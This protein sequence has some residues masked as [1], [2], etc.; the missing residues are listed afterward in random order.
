MPFL[1]P[2]AAVAFSAISIGA[3]IAAAAGVTAFLGLSIATWSTIAMVGMAAT[4][5]ASVLTM[6]KAPK[7]ESQMDPGQQLGTKVIGSLG[8]LPVVYGRT[9]VG[10][11]LVY[12]STHG[13]NNKFWTKAHVLS[14]AGPIQE[15]EKYYASEWE[16]QLTGNPL[17]SL[18]T[19]SGLVGTEAGSKLYK[20]KVKVAYSLG[21][22]PEASTINAR[23]GGSLPLAPGA[24]SGVAYAL[25]QYDYDQEAFSGGD[26]QN[27][28]VIKG[29]KAYDP[30]LDST[31]TGGAGPQRLDDQ[32]T[33]VFT[34]NPYIA[35]LH[36][37]LG[38]YVGEVRTAGL[39]V[40]PDEIDWHAFITG[41]NVCDANDWK[42][43]GEVL[44]NDEPF[45]VLAA[46]LQAGCGVPISRGAQISCYVCAPQVSVR[47]ITA[48]DVVGSYENTNSTPWRGRK[49]RVVP[50]YRS[51]AKFWKAVQGD[52]IELAGAVEQDG[53]TKTYELNFGMVQDATQAHQLAA[54][55]LCNNREFLTFEVTCKPQLLGVRVGETIV[56]DLPDV[57]ANEIKCLVMGREF[58]PSSCTVRLSL[59]SETDTKH[60]FALGLTN[61]EPIPPTL[62]RFD[63][64]LV[65][66]PLSS[67][68]KAEG[69]VVIDP[70]GGETP[71]I[72]VTGACGNP[73]IHTIVIEH[74]LAGS[75]EWTHAAEGGRESTRF[76]LQSGIQGATAYDVA[77]SYR[78]VRGALSGRLILNDITT[79]S[80]VFPDQP[81]GPVDY[82]DLTGLPDALTIV[83]GYLLAE[84]LWEGNRTVQDALEAIDL[85]QATFDLTLQGVADDLQTARDDIGT[86][87]QNLI[88]AEGD[89]DVRM[90]G[91]DAAIRLVDPTAGSIGSWF[92]LAETNITGAVTRISGMESNSLVSLNDNAAFANFPTPSGM[93]A[94]WQNW[95]SSA[96]LSRVAGQVSP[97]GV[98]VIGP[99]NDNGGI[100]SILNP[101]LQN[102]RQNQWLVLEADVTLNSGS[103][104]SAALY[105]NIIT[106]G[107]VFLESHQI[108]FTI[109]PDN[110]GAVV[111]AGVVG[112]TYRYSKLIRVQHASA[113]WAEV[114]CMAHY[115]A[116]G[117][118]A[119]ANSITFHKAVLRQATNMEIEVG[120]ASVGSSLSAK[121]INADTVLTNGSL[122]SA[123]SVSNLS[124]ELSN[125]REG[126]PTLL[127]NIGTVRQASVDG[128]AGKASASEFSII[129]SEVEGARGGAASLGAKIG[130]FS[131]TVADALTGKASAT[132]VTTLEARGR[133][134]PNLIP[135]GFEN[136]LTGWVSA[137]NKTWVAVDSSWGRSVRMTNVP[138]SGI[139]VLHTLPFPV[140]PGTYYSITGDS[141][142]IGGTAI[143]YFDFIFFADDGSAVDGPQNIKS[144]AHDFSE[145]DVNRN[146]Y[147]VEAQ[148]PA[149]ATSAIA[150][151]IIDGASGVNYVGVRMV[152]AQ[153]GRLPMTPFSSEASQLQNGA[154][155]TTLKQVTVDLETNKASAQSVTDLTTEITNARGGQANLSARITD[156]ATTASD[157]NTATATRATNLE[158]NSQ[159]GALNR[160]ANFARDWEQGAI[161]PNWFDWAYGYN[162]LK[163]SGR[164]GAYAFKQGGFPNANGGLGQ[165]VSGVI[166]GW[167][168]FEADITLN[169]GPLTATGMHVNLFNAGGASVSSFNYS[170]AQEKDSTQSIPGA[171][172]PGRNYR[173]A[174]LFRLPVTTGSFA[175]VYLMTKWDGLGNVAAANDVT[176]HE[177]RFRQA[178][179]AEIS[180]GEAEL[181][182]SLS[183]SVTTAANVE[184]S[185]TI[186]KA[187]LITDIKSE[188]EGARSGQPTLS[189][190]FGS[191]T[192]TVADALTGK[193]S[194]TD[195][196]TLNTEVQNARQGFGSLSAKVDN[197]EQAIS[198]GDT[199]I[200]TR[201]TSIEARVGGVDSLFLNPIFQSYTT[202][203]SHPEHWGYWVAPQAIARA[204]GQ[205]GQFA[206]TMTT[207]TSESGLYQVAQVPL[208]GWFV[209]EADVVLNG[210]NF[211]GA[212]M[213]FYVQNAPGVSLNFHTE[214]DIAGT[215]Q[216]SPTAGRLYSFRKLVNI[217]TV[218]SGVGLLHLMNN[219]NS[220]GFY[221]SSA[222]TITWHKCSVRPATAGEIETGQARGIH[223][224]L[225]SKI[226]DVVTVA[227]NANQTTANSVTALNSA[228]NFS[229]NA[230]SDFRAYTTTT[231]V[232]TG[233][234]DWA[235]AGNAVRAA[236]VVSPYGFRMTG[237]SVYMGIQALYAGSPNMADMRAGYYVLSA[238]LTLNSGTLVGSGVLLNFFTDTSHTTHVEGASL[239]FSADPSTNGSVVGAGVGGTTYHF[240]KLVRATSA[241]SRVAILYA[242]QAYDGFGSIAGPRDITFHEASVRPATE[243]EIVVGTPT[244]GLQATVV[245]QGQTLARVDGRTEAWW[246][247]TAAAGAEPATARLYADGF[248]SEIAL[249][250]KSIR[251]LNV[252]GGNTVE[253]LKLVGGFA[254]FGAPISSDYNGHRLTMGPAFGPSADVVM[255]YGPNATTI[256]NCSRTNGYFALGTDGGVYKGTQTLANVRRE[257]SHRT[258]P[259]GHAQAGQ[260]FGYPITSGWDNALGAWI[261][262]AAHTAHLNDQTSISVPYAF[263]SQANGLSAAGIIYAMFYQINNGAIIQPIPQTHSSYAPVLAS[264][265]YVWLGSMAVPINSGGNYP[266][267]PPNSTP[268]NGTR[269]RTGE[270]MNTVEP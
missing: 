128:L 241:G 20:N 80:A 202:T 255:W 194:A 90:D 220:G 195:F 267:P 42:V 53:G 75:T 1:I 54:Y 37:L 144:D 203:T 116:F 83:N 218:G 256:A 168:V 211:A 81:Q 34:E 26:P 127:A 215:V 268:P 260:P 89:F 124:T 266:D 204:V 259:P 95:A 200:A 121:V 41:A 11:S 139:E 15:I 265:E 40:N 199:A 264:V 76:A 24:L 222:K 141:C 187:N 210:G 185:G 98:V 100:F 92:L 18:A 10:G 91:I 111:G 131:G 79:G 43:G 149:N 122:A 249:S 123:T 13:T 7:P 29:V 132:S 212:G 21:A 82:D 250:A 3:G 186:A 114:Y 67:E 235:N 158:A 33:W 110:T 164:K 88:D 174:K 213:L 48:D 30:R 152:Q 60:A 49:N 240:R 232:P 201:A 188:V 230:N 243:A 182:G 78:T 19:V 70:S 175:Y 228:I 214:P 245:S 258:Y 57:A 36:Y 150:R 179:A 224:N 137:T 4:M 16:T 191:F 154:S 244:S 223:A 237:S 126:Q 62:T 47:T 165:L 270:Q 101:A 106:S 119:A 28:W 205:R 50:T 74:R 170:F 151:F 63:P 193:A 181:Q 55:D 206:V 216:S 96:S 118:V 169:A 32:A 160:N 173:F 163:V 198:D 147:A 254:Y 226:A 161:P 103:L 208:S 71:A 9:A 263:Y 2:V 180:V 257:V 157:N 25:T 229:I 85:A 166:G 27:K 5:V 189:A 219:W 238:T 227:S 51:E 156:V 94:G 153:R 108:I 171:G 17:A 167:F 22:I 253:A 142:R 262:V 246:D 177:A 207:D 12:Q 117:S 120:K 184:T 178:S 148:A 69:T 66:A 52:A 87:N 73:N 190:R 8:P 129:K 196:S 134:R 6:P 242:M 64:T 133:S 45:A 234:T 59:R 162:A 192:G 130:N 140:T 145:D 231:G 58:D 68:W 99:A 217:P 107:S 197:L 14:A 97:Y 113:A 23:G 65:P 146:F 104:Q 239:S 84:N 102:I 46:I 105:T 261:S 136:G 236:G 155:I 61:V 31:F 251:L 248:G 38:H 44:S 172:V 115:S 56:V 209:L 221:T 35:G 135:G 138:F 183:A 269:S 109:D 252:S 159:G 247:I 77:I 233:W 125:A 72:I 176:W 112:N 225:T 86:A 39:G 93:P 143:T